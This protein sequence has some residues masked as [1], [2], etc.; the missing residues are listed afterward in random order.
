MLEYTLKWASLKSQCPLAAATRR[1]KLG[2]LRLLASA[3]SMLSL[4]P[5]DRIQVI[6]IHSNS[7]LKNASL[8]YLNSIPKS[9]PQQFEIG[10]VE[11]CSKNA[12]S[13]KRLRTNMGRAAKLDL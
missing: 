12:A 2:S 11:L 1:V 8:F 3:I 10:I 4:N 5:S 6:N 7:E 9:L 13:P